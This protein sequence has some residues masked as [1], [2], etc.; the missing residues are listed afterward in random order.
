VGFISGLSI[1]RWGF[2]PNFY[3]F[4]LP[5]IPEAHIDSITASNTG[6]LVR[7][8][9][10]VDMAYLSTREGKSY[11]LQYL[12]Q[13]KAV[14]KQYNLAVDKSLLTDLVPWHFVIHIHD[15]SSPSGTRMIQSFTLLGYDDLEKTAKLLKQPNQEKHVF[16]NDDSEDEQFNHYLSLCQ[17][18]AVEGNYVALHF[19]DFDSKDFETLHKVMLDRYAFANATFDAYTRIKKHV[20]GVCN[21]LGVN[22]KRVAEN[23]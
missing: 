23:T 1:K 7:S 8:V 2:W 3:A 18:A 21:A 12:E 4:N 16:N 6:G 17:Y 5:E 15:A 14:I 9:M 11:E 10:M 20:D 19:N 13:L 22:L